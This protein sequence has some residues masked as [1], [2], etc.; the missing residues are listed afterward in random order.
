M[1]CHPTYLQVKQNENILIRWVGCGIADAHRTEAPP[2]SSTSSD[3]NRT[4]LDYGEKNGM[5]EEN[6]VNVI[7]LKIYQKSSTCSRGEIRKQPDG[8]DDADSVDGNEI[9]IKFRVLKPGEIQ[10]KRDA[11]V[12]PNDII[13]R[14]EQAVKPTTSVKLLDRCHSTTNATEQVE[15]PRI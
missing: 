4:G 10:K 7:Q 3:S 6:P 1:A 5:W 13:K 9:V 15:R 14:E 11:R 8:V 12:V 2:S